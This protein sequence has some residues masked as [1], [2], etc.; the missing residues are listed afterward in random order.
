LRTALLVATD[1]Q[2]LPFANQRIDSIIAAQTTVKRLSH[3]PIRL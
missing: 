1:D 3:D 2:T